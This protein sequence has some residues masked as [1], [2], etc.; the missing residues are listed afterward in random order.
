[1]IAL[2]L[3]KYTYGFWELTRNEIRNCKQLAFNWAAYSRT[4][5]EIKKRADFLI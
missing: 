5:D 1:V 3:Y 2:S 4:A